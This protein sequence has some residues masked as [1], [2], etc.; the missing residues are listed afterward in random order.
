LDGWA[1]RKHTTRCKSRATIGWYGSGAYCVDETLNKN[2]PQNLSLLAR[3][4]AP[5]DVDSPIGRVLERH[6]QCSGSGDVKHLTQIAGRTSIPNISKITIASKLIRVLCPSI[7]NRIASFRSSG[8]PCIRQSLI[9]RIADP[10]SFRHPPVQ[11]RREETVTRGLREISQFVQV[12][13]DHRRR[14][15]RPIAR[16]REDAGFG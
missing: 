5:Q 14:E 8:G 2:P 3:R 9:C 6:F 4:S 7:V 16:N 12:L 13:Q 1:K 15:N 11:R 10:K